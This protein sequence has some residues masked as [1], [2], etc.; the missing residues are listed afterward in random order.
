MSTSKMFELTIQYIYSNLIKYN[1]MAKLHQ[2]KNGGI[3]NYEFTMMYPTVYY[4]MKTYLIDTLYKMSS[5]SGSGSTFDTGIIQSICNSL[6]GNITDK[7]NSEFIKSLT[8]SLDTYPITAKQIIIDYCEIFANDNYKLKIDAS[9]HYKLA[10]FYKL[11]IPVIHKFYT[12]MDKC[13]NDINELN[14]ITRECGIE[15]MKGTYLNTYCILINEKII[16][17][18]N[19]IYT[20]LISF[21]EQYYSN[22]NLFLQLEKI[23]IV[24]QQIPIINKIESRLPKNKI[25]NIYNNKK[26][27]YTKDDLFKIA[28]NKNIIGASKLTIPLLEKAILQTIDGKTLQDKSIKL[29]LDIDSNVNDKGIT[30]AILELLTGHLII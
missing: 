9:N 12:E 20:K 23:N 29:K 13:F 11:I 18:Y 5:G 24:P 27:L 17:T 2:H 30:T 6:S 1:E 16:K 22:I 3:V 21:L 28:V 8:N 14:K 19:P 4:N 7:Y 10:Y 25:T 15:Y 26:T